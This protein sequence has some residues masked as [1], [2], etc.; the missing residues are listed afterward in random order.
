MANVSKLLPM[1]VL[2]VGFAGTGAGSTLVPF[3]APLTDRN[4]VELGVGVRFG[5][6]RLSFDL[7]AETTVE[8]SDLRQQ[9]YRAAISYRF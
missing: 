9:T 5:S 1:L 2:A 8:R 3:F 4:W 7:S 6:D